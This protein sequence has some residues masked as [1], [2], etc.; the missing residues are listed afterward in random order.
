M[1]L[2]KHISPVLLTLSLAGVVVSV[3]LSSARG[4][5][6]YAVR[7][8]GLLLRAVVAVDVIPPLAAVLLMRYLP[9]DSAV[10]AG[11]VLMAISPVPPLSPGQELKVGARREYAYGL[12]VALALLTIVTVPMAL[13]IATA[14]FGRQDT[15]SVATLAKSLLVGVFIP[16][17][18][19]V[20][21]RAVAPGFAARVAPWLYRL[22]APLVSLAFL[23]TIASSWP[24][25]M[26][27]VGDGALLA[28][29]LVVLIALAGGH[30]LGGPDRIDRGTLAIASAVRHPGI[31][32][33][34]AGANFTDA[35]VS[36][37]VLLFMLVGLVIGLPYK[38]WLKRT[39]ATSV[40][41]RP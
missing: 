32:M 17:A 33:M 38:Q 12:Y 23:P 28:M 10:K 25:I 1:E 22:G 34:L 13:A 27:L 29:A 15:V 6:L 41:S 3:G 2:L 18:I 26:S 36:A 37:A 11:V 20:A 5:F 39:G 40:A 24:A 19:G 21:V 35:R 14:A 4:D 7:R 16:L 9:L 30:F 8:P 31:A